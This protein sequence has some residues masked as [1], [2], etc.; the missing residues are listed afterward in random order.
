MGRGWRSESENVE[1][2]AAA[3]PLGVTASLVR[4]GHP[5][6]FRGARQLEMRLTPVV[7]EE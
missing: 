1:K 2:S 5:I 3:G 6:T 4:L 7:Y